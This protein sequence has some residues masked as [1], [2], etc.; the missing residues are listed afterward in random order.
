MSEDTGRRRGP[1]GEAAFLERLRA[2]LP[3]PP[4]GQE[5][6]G[7][8][9]AVLE[10]GLLFATDALV[11]AVHFDL[12]WCTAADVGWKALVVNLSDLAAMGGTPRA[13]VVALVVPP[14][15]GGLAEGVIEGVAGAAATFGCPLV[16]GDTTGGPVL[17]VSVAVLG[18][19]AP[20]GAV[21][22]RG[23]QVGDAVFVTG[24][25]G[26]AAAAL[27]ALRN[28]QTPP[29]DA[30]ARLVRPTP[31]LREGAAAAAAGATAMIDLS[32]GLATDLGHLCEASAVGVHINTSDVPLAEGAAFADAFQ[33]DD[34]ELCFTASDPTTVAARFAAS[35]C[36]PP[37]RI[38]T[39]TA[40][41]RILVDTDGRQR[42]LP[43]AGWEH[44]VP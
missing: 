37:T 2:R 21:L 39:I 16:G 35:G 41:E 1:A 38:G 31:R 4:E 14:A 26:A 9:A 28:R 44:T 32:D 42:P 40:G 24:A 34:Y 10:D 20:T 8:D 5:W 13:A 22:R 30:L 3:R 19:C 6:I 25:L 29:P 17:M 27:A 43:Q 11:E 18:T 23:A 36:E 12:R 33:G 7:D 15:R